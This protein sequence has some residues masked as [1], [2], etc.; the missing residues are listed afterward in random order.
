[1]GNRIAENRTLIDNNKLES[2]TKY[3]LDP[4]SGVLPRL[5]AFALDSHFILILISEAAK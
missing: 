3:L 2:R 1:M 5:I 4:F